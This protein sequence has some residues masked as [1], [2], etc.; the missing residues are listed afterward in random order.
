MINLVLIIK[1]DPR[2]VLSLKTLEYW[3]VGKVMHM[4]VMHLVRY[5]LVYYN[6]LYLSKN[7]HHQDKIR[8]LIQ[9]F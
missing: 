5:L 6:E 4:C 1:I 7:H 8:N 2:V 3:C 9:V